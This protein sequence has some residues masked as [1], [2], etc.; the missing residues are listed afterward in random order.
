MA[1]L[2][3]PLQRQFFEGTPSI[4]NLNMDSHDKREFGK[5]AKV[6]NYINAIESIIAKSETLKNWAYVS[7]GKELLEKLKYIMELRLGSDEYTFN[8]ASILIGQSVTCLLQLANEYIKGG[9]YYL[10]EDH[11]KKYNMSLISD[12]QKADLYRHG[13]TNGK[14]MDPTKGEIDV[15]EFKQ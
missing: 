2:V 6:S 10:S 11:K 8:N 4:Y 13:F 9:N 15:L 1:Y 7:Y 14:Y 3:K 5:L 12:D